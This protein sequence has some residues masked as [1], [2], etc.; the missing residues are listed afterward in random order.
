MPIMWVFFAD[1]NNNLSYVDAKDYDRYVTKTWI[2]PSR[3]RIGLVKDD[4]FEI[5]K[6]CDADMF[7]STIIHQLSKDDVLIMN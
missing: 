3:M 5:L 2:K 1:S 6:W 7:A 4:C